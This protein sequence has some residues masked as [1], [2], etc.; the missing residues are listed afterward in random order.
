MSANQ[1]LA[2][3]DYQKKVTLSESQM[4]DHKKELVPSHHH[5]PSINKANLMHLKK[6]S[7]RSIST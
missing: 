3:I 7:E 2:L 5:G 4:I 1:N 6:I